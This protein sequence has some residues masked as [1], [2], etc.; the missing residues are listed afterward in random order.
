MN[1]CGD[2]TCSVCGSSPQIAELGRPRPMR[3]WIRWV[4]VR[5]LRFAIRR[6]PEHVLEL[7]QGLER[8]I[9]R[10]RPMETPGLWREACQGT[11]LEH[12]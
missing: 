4:I 9:G 10:H 7:R 5:A 2:P 12:F 8:F 11:P 1:V 3:R 6:R